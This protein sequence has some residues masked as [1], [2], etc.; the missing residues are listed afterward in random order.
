M[1]KLNTKVQKDGSV[2]MEISVL[3]GPYIV[4]L[5]HKLKELDSVE[6]V[7]VLRGFFG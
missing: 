2:R 5:E 1:S 4:N 6:S 7:K 3:D